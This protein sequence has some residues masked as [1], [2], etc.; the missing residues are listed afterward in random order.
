MRGKPV[1]NKT[2]YQTDRK[3]FG[4]KSVIIYSNWNEIFNNIMRKIIIKKKETKTKIILFFFSSCNFII[5]SLFTLVYELFNTT[6]C[7]TG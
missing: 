5:I 2:S 3:S 4:N 1:K 6:S 7:I